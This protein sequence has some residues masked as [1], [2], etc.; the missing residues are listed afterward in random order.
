MAIA[1]AKQLNPLHSALYMY[2]EAKNLLPRLSI[3][4]EQENSV[5][6]VQSDLDRYLNGLRLAGLE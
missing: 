2:V 5:L 6:L 3:A 4:D 1:R